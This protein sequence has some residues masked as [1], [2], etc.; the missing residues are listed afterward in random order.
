MST[1]FQERLQ[2]AM[3]NLKGARQWRPKDY[4]NFA[5]MLMRMPRPGSES[6]PP[7]HPAQV[8]LTMFTQ[9]KVSYE[10]D[11]DQSPVQD[12]SRVEEAFPHTL[13]PTVALFVDAPEHLSGVS[14]TLQGW[15]EEAQRQGRPFFLHMA[16]SECRL[17]GGKCFPKVGS[18]RMSSYDG[19]EIPVP[20]VK[21]V[22]SYMRGHPFDVAHLSTPG[23][24]GL[25][26]MRLARDAGVPVCGTYHT[27]FPRYVGEL[28]G[29]PDL[30]A[31]TWAFMVWFYGQM[32]RVA[33]PSE[34][35]RQ[36][37]IA[38]GLDPN[39]VRV[40]GRGVELDQFSPAHRDE[41]LR[42]SWGAEE[43]T[44]VLIYVGRVSREKNLPLLT[45]AY[46]KLLASGRKATLVVVGDGP[47][48]EE[49]MRE[50]AGTPAVFTGVLK[51]ASLSA[52]FASGDLF[53][54]PSETDTFGRVIIE[55]QA[56]GVPVLV[57][58]RGGPR[59]AMLPER[60]GRVVDGVTPGRFADALKGVLADP[61]RLA[62][63]KRDARI[64][65]CRYTP[66]AS[67]DAFWNLHR[68][69]LKPQ[70]KSHVAN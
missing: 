12:E 16:A 69:A 8:A 62:R 3:E 48:R 5:N 43:H 32:D 63:W 64:H 54:F 20:D 34:S 24:M 67:F 38:H 45:A 52:A 31:F 55:A 17:P 25:M 42:Q 37:L 57:S 1:V 61:E 47:Y 59:D 13:E 29:N 28:T 22:S 14:L 36:D 4:V 26:G 10:P 56:S 51:G 58:D 23:P 18:L 39:R 21:A 11:Q 70:E 68:F 49:M 9:M 40:V 33:A 44:P 15:A 41:D 53:V 66:A 65:A 46:K 6:G 7:L 19:L 30:E 27:D 60:T 2:T 35:T 50:L